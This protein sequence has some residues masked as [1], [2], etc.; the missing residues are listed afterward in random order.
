MNSLVTLSRLTA[1]PR[2]QIGLLA[3]L[4]G[5][6][7]VAFFLAPDALARSSVDTA[8]VSDSFRRGFVAYWG[9]GSE[10]FPTRLSATVDFWFRFH[11]V[12]AGVSAL[13]LAVAL[14]LGVVLS[15]Y[16]RQRTSGRAGRLGLALS[17]AL[18]GVLGLFALVALVANLQGAAA[19]F[20][21]LLP[22]LTSGGAPDGELTATLAQVRQQIAV[23]PEG[24]HSPAL[25]VMISDFALY[26]WVLAGLAAVVALAMAGASVVSWRRL[27]T[28][29]DARS[30][31]ASA[32]GGVVSAVL[33]AVV[34][35]IAYANT[36]NAADSPR[37]LADFFAGGW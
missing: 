34:L 8:N 33:A 2:R 15:R 1:T 22:M 29:S 23:Y 13:L 14:A 16:V 32:F 5:A 19:P 6:V 12:K 26:H 21:S 3:A 31:R 11:L 17:R 18:V 7:L 30:R 25:T 20:A 36:T 28:S 37:A 35:V 10:D 27:T 24:R 9:S 4:A